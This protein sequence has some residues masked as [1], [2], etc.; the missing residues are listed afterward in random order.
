MAMSGEPLTCPRI[1]PNTGER[2]G[3][4]LPDGASY[5]PC[6]GCRADLARRATGWAW[7]KTA[8]VAQA[9]ADGYVLNEAGDAF[10]LPKVDDE[11][12]EV[13]AGDRAG[14]PARSAR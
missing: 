3:R 14:P 1:D 6:P 8:R 4:P 13:I 10:V 12:D 7:E 5:G 9:F 11:P 2:C